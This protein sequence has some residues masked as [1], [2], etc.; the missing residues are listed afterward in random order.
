M[1]VPE[2][3][4]KKNYLTTIFIVI[5]CLLALC[6]CQ[7]NEDIKTTQPEQSNVKTYACVNLNCYSNSDCGSK[8]VCDRQSNSTLGKCIA[9]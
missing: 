3:F 9:K 6:G 1:A 4:L 7:Q 2:T 8:C 5:F